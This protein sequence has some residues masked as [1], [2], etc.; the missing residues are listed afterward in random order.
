MK[1]FPSLYEKSTTGK[2]KVWSISVDGS[3][4]KT[5]YGLLGGKMT[6]TSDE[7]KSGKN[8]GRANATTK[9]QQ[10][11]AEAKSRWEKKLKSG[12][13]ESP[14]GAKAGLVDVGFVQGG[15]EPMLAKDFKDCKKVS[16]PAYVQP[17]LDGIRCV[18]VVSSGEVSLWTRTR[19]PIASMKHIVED[20]KFR[21]KGASVVLDGELYNHNYKDKFEEI[22]SLVRKDHFVPEAE[23]V[24]YHVY[25]VVDTAK[26][27]SVRN[28]YLQQHIVD[29]TGSSC[30]KLVETRLAQ[31][32]DDVNAAH[33]EFVLQGYEGAMYRSD[34][35]YENKRSNHLLKVKTFQSDEFEIVDL[36]DGR[37]KMEGAAVMVCRSEEGDEFRC[38]MVGSI[39]YLRW[40]FSDRDRVIGKKLTVKFQGITGGRVPRFPVGVAI[41]DYE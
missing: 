2:I 9:E 34:S 18:A 8:L 20:L 5:S 36:E 4:I 41:R 32:E 38:K 33:T 27:F 37:G 16:Y 14:E 22:V 28:L 15:V 13:V 3:T 35:A 23:T 31:S 1:T 6:T 7:V 12:Y 17:K 26:T 29:P 10:A 39:E 25:D 40:I 11:E 30:V 19:K 24:Q 21:F